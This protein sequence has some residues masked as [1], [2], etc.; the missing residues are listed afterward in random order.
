MSSERMY[1]EKQLILC[2]L[3]SVFF[4]MEFKRKFNIEDSP[5][6]PASSNYSSMRLCSI[7]QLQV[8]ISPP[9]N[10]PSRLCFK[11]SSSTERSVLQLNFDPPPPHPH[12]L[13][14][15][16]FPNLLRPP[17]HHQDRIPGGRHL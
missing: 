9:A 3:I 2:K 10:H 15:K 1:I 8:C 17:L 5:S 11:S 4:K 13:D 16:L 14:S 6:P 7:N 12:H